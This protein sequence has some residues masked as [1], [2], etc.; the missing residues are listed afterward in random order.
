[1]LLSVIKAFSKPVKISSAVTKLIEVFEFECS[2]N[3]IAAMALSYV[4]P[5]FI[6][7][8]LSEIKLSASP[9][10]PRLFLIQ[11]N[12]SVTLLMLHMFWDVGM[13][14]VEAAVGEALGIFVGLTDG[15]PVGLRVG[16]NVGEELGAVVGLAVGRAV[17]GADVG[18]AVGA[19]VGDA[20]GTAVAEVGLVVGAKV[21]APVGRKDGALVGDAVGVIDGVAVGDTVGP[22]EGN[23]VGALVGL[24][25]GGATFVNVY[26]ALAGYPDFET[27]SSCSNCTVPEAVGNDLRPI[28][29]VFAM[30]AEEHAASEAI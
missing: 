16:S 6:V 25:V 24:L 13:L 8:D 17:V 22:A 3:D 12:E 5:R 18:P 10:V 15:V 21:G 11:A 2:I 20:V 27:G 23:G 30:L 28:D 9:V 4:Y 1:L 29:T 7:H 26:V 14:N 19:V